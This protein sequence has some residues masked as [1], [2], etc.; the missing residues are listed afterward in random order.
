MGVAAPWGTAQQ[1]LIDGKTPFWLHSF[2][3][4]L[5]RRWDRVSFCEAFDGLSQTILP[6]EDYDVAGLLNLR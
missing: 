4:G 3:I 5:M 6:A 1:N 2:P